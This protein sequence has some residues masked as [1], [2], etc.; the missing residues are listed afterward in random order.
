MPHSPRVERIDVSPDFVNGITA[1]R[2]DVV[3]VVGEEVSLGSISK[4]GAL[5]ALR[6]AV[7]NRRSATSAGKRDV[8]TVRSAACRT[9]P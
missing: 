5:L 2:S 1:K 6:K 8:E 4:T 3:V 7:D 9:R